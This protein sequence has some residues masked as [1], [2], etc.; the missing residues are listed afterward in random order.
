LTSSSGVSSTLAG[1]RS[2]WRVPCSCA[3]SS[4]RVI[5]SRSRSLSRVVKGVPRFGG[6]PARRSVAMVSARLWCRVAPAQ[7]KQRSPCCENSSGAQRFRSYGESS[8]RTR[9]SSFVGVAPPPS[10]RRRARG[11]LDFV[12][13][14]WS[15]PSGILERKFRLPTE[16]RSDISS[17]CLD[18][19]PAADNDAVPPR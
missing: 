10:C 15:S 11:I 16:F 8:T 18:A 19:A 4:A 17:P 9:C 7:P 1:L 14:L 5:C 6:T 2:R 13:I 12:E 3:R